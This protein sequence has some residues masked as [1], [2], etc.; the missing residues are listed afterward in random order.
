MHRLITCCLF[1]LDTT[2]AN[3]EKTRDR[4]E[5]AV[6]PDKTSSLEN[7]K[8][9]EQSSDQTG[10]SSRTTASSASSK[11]SI[12]I[13]PIFS[14]PKAKKPSF[15]AEEG[16]Q[17][18]D[19]VAREEAYDPF[20][21]TET[22]EELDEVME[23]KEDDEDI[24]SESAP[25]PS[26][27]SSD[28]EFE[29]IPVINEETEAVET[30]KKE[31]EINVHVEDDF[32]IDIFAEEELEKA[33][34]EA[35]RK[36]A[37]TVRPDPLK[38]WRDEVRQT[39]VSEDLHI[40][41]P[42]LR[43]KGSS[44]I[45][46]KFKKRSR[47]D[48]TNLP[49]QDGSMKSHYRTRKTSD[50]K[51]AKKKNKRVSSESP[52]PQTSFRK[53]EKNTF[54]PVPPPSTQS[55]RS[56]TNKVFAQHEA[57]S[58][59]TRNEFQYVQNPLRSHHRR[60]ANKP[61]KKKHSPERERV[62]HIS[63]TSN[64]SYKDDAR[65]KKKKSLPNDESEKTKKKKRKVQEPDF[66]RAKKE[67]RV[68]KEK[69]ETYKM[70]SPTN[71]QNPPLSYNI[72][73]D[74]DLLWSLNP[75]SST[76]DQVTLPVK[77]KERKSQKRESRSRHRKDSS[78]ENN[79]PLRRTYS[80]YSSERELES[81]KKKKRKC[82]PKKKKHSRSPKKRVIKKKK[83]NNNHSTNSDLSVSNNNLSFEHIFAD[84]DNLKKTK[85]KKRKE[86]REKKSGDSD[87]Q[88]VFIEEEV[89]VIYDDESL[90]EGE[91]RSSGDE[92]KRLIKR[93]INYTNETPQTSS[94]LRSIVVAKPSSGV[95]NGTKT[96]V[97]T[98]TDVEASKVKSQLKLKTVHK[99]HS[100][101]SV[102]NGHKKVEQSVAQQLNES[103]EL[104]I[105][106]FDDG[107]V[108]EEQEMDSESSSPR[109]S[110]KQNDF[111]PVIS[112][113]PKAEIALS[114][115]N[116]NSTYAVVNP[117]TVKTKNQVQLSHPPQSLL[118]PQTLQ[119]TKA[120]PPSI[121][122][123]LSP[124]SF[125]SFKTP[126]FSP[127]S[128]P[129]FPTKSKE[130]V[131]TSQIPEP[132]T[133]KS[134][135]YVINDDNNAGQT[136]TSSMTCTTSAVVSVSNKTPIKY[137]IANSTPENIP[138]HPQLVDEPASSAPDILP[139][140]DY[141]KTMKRE[142]FANSSDFDE[143]DAKTSHNPVRFQAKESKTKKFD[144]STKSS[145]GNQTLAF[146]QFNQPSLPTTYVNKTSSNQVQSQIQTIYVT[147]SS[148]NQISTQFQ[149]VYVNQTSSNQV[150]F[151]PTVYFTQ[152]PTNQTSFQQQVAPSSA[153]SKYRII[154]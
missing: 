99:P 114:N 145:S 135:S 1:S 8:K 64:S 72:D 54:S 39:S 70:P 146:A 124:K 18:E 151:M 67:R 68:E 94:A 140:V 32:E 95:I 7:A 6:K 126:P 92:I 45:P 4:P 113:P 112:D 28:E 5:N 42:T 16:W 131:P 33:Q 108:V 136:S 137:V 128:S 29:V 93:K 109:A 26:S 21:P 141:L 105:L 111:G 139:L 10:F 101:S 59:E 15:D 118:S 88:I 91:I 153:V 23:D 110:S 123:L 147:P 138:N 144:E 134:K 61:G 85:K 14:L 11:S 154:C 82:L 149:T 20:R 150:P 65:L 127:R 119:S 122:T 97:S 80:S 50:S 77:N 43:L 53:R 60:E 102:K 98:A 121:K 69:W 63:S 83:I 49:Q 44:P 96:A 107:I 12:M 86:E 9:S 148:S 84:F 89:P 66:D 51:N 152:M 34:D 115:D 120:N 13:K 41:L 27:S 71:P 79:N 116:P 24:L 129:I 90:S 62:R 46:M 103:L 22:D 48:K 35:N 143:K 40:T 25:E 81:K 36:A 57:S 132:A 19:A 125:P 74:D 55:N 58:Y 87:E 130:F 142:S 76:T 56:K 117:D 17:P 47:K 30:T 2:K 75:P 100:I 133:V 38:M 31:P 3:E 52:E 73:I 78:V 104:D 37:E 106:E